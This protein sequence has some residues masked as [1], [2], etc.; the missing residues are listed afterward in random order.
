MEFF[1]ESQPNKD[2]NIDYKR[3]LYRA[4]RFWYVITLC[5]VLA[6]VAAF[7]TNR[8]ATRIY[9]VTASIIIKEAGDISGSE[10]LYNNPLVNYHRN[11]LNELYIIKSHPLIERV[12]V[13]LNFAVSFYR[14]GNI[15][16][17]EVYDIPVS[18]TVLNPDFFQSKR[19]IFTPL[20]NSEF[21]LKYD[22]ASD[23]SKEK[24]LFG[25]TIDYNGLRA[26]FNVKHREKLKNYFNQPFIFIYT[27]PRLLTA[28]YIQ[29][30][31]ASWAHEGA[32]V[33]N[34]SINGPNPDKEKDFLEGFIERYQQYDLEN[35]NETASRIVDFITG[36]LTSISDS[37]RIVELELEQFKDRNV[38]TDLGAESLR[39][40]KRLEELEL[41]KTQSILNENYYQYLNNY[42]ENNENLNY[43]I[44]PNSLGISDPSLMSLVSQLQ[45]IQIDL[46]S[47]LKSENPLLAEPRRKLNEIK[48]EIFEAIKSLRSTD[49]IRIDFI[50]GKI[51]D[52]EKQLSRLPVAE[53]RLVAIQRNYTLLENLY[54]FLLQKRSEAAISSASNSSD[55]ILVNPPMAE[56]A[57]SPKIKQN[58]FIAAILGIA[59]PIL[60]FILLELV[61]TRIQSREDIE[62]VTSIPFSGGV[63]HKR[64]DN[65]LEVFTNPKTS[66]AESFRALRSNLNYFLGKN[67]KVVILITSSIS[68]EGKTFTSINLAAVFALS[69]KRV[70]I[71]GADMRKPK[72]YPDF[73]LG[74]EIGLSGYLSGLSTFDEVVQKT[75][76]EGLD[77][78]SGGPVPPNPSE[79]LLTQRIE[80]FLAEAKKQYDYVIID[81]PPLAIVT[82]AFAL[83]PFADHTLFLVRQ[84][85]TPKDLLRTAQDFY[86]T[87]K[88][89]NISIVLNDI[90]KSGPGYGYGYGYTYGYG[91]GNGYSKSKNGY[92][93][94]S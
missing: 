24:F 72:L 91:Y 74:N 47:Q 43:V 19:L 11:Y 48:R 28:T 84:N 13:D 62:K 21:E 94:Y 38:V 40:Y 29:K 42:L 36:Q 58:Y 76:Y 9:P 51:Q 27:S 7:L 8:Y 15:L 23:E 90:Y 82:D 68:G 70:L 45:S 49:K 12:L 37:L 64:S 73:N 54:I 26:V 52:E 56:G 20:N 59:L 55:I 46:N 83:A 44:L 78:V 4:I 30:L 79:L 22:Q 39:L 1:A 6:I 25:D 3:I 61:N 34:L 31:N 77:L 85:Y 75:S 14:E 2:W 16:T 88:L 5:L 65:N 66:I 69:G 41:E 10:L 63:G 81:T 33:I 80:T 17:S 53:R 89:K 60:V 35:K 67:E 87:G 32:G 86:S 93:Y 71:V 18:S 92:G 57:I 50:S